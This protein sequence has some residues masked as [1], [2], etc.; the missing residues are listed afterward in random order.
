MGFNLI[1]SDVKFKFAASSLL[2]MSH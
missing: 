1:F 2:V